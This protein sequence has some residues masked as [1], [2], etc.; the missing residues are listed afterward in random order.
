MPNS[1]EKES[2]VSFHADVTGADGTTRELKISPVK[3]LGH[4]RAAVAVLCNVS[5]PE[6]NQSRQVAEK[7]FTSSRLTRFIYAFFFQAPFPYQRN[8]DAIRASLFRRLVIHDLMEFA[9]L[10]N[11]AIALP[12]YTRW[13]DKKN[14]FVLGSEYVKGRPIVPAR[15]DEFGVRR[16]LLNWIARPMV[17]VFGIKRRKI[18]KEKS[19][20]SELLKIMRNMERLLRRAGLVGSGWQVATRTLVATANFLK[21]S[22]TDSYVL[23]DTESGI[24]AL[25]VPSYLAAGL[26]YGFPLFDSI[27]GDKKLRRFFENNRRDIEAKLGPGR[28]G[29]F[30]GH[31]DKLIFHTA[32]WKASE[33]AIFRHHLKLFLSRSLK[34]KVRSKTL[35]YWNKDGIFSDRHWEKVN[36]SRRIFSSSYF[37]LSILPTSMGK[38]V[39]LF[40]CNDD[41]RAKVRRFFKDKAYRSHLL[42]ERVDKKLALWQREGRVSGK[43]AKEIAGSKWRTNRFFLHYLAAVITPFGFRRIHRVLSDWDYAKDAFWKSCLALMSERYQL[44]LARSFISKAIAQDIMD[45]RLEP[46]IAR[47]L[48]MVVDRGEVEE[49]IRC[50]GWHLGLKTLEYFTSSLKV[51]GVTL[52]AATGNILYLLLFINTSLIRTAYTLKRMFK[53]RGRGISY[54]SALA[55]GMIP[56]LGT[57]AFPVQMYS[58]RKDFSIYLMRHLCSALGQRAPIYGG[59]STVT[60][61]A[62]VKC[63]D[64][65][66]EPLEIFRTWAEGLKRLFRPKPSETEGVTR[67]VGIRKRT[68]EPHESSSRLKTIWLNREQQCI[69]LLDLETPQGDSS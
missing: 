2:P 69:D 67:P 41:Y 51:M 13:D 1:F 18:E 27:A 45:G 42:R 10:G 11:T 17:R 68:F 24:P 33:P 62:A 57:F 25:L 47:G 64:F 21:G 44:S 14:S 48:S 58:I 52:W 65:I 37:F 5:G 22:S 20:L 23:V 61:F 43:I 59:K 63:V 39:W 9:G 32:Q 7:V 50:F 3:T 53:N 38:G 35:F 46:R 8:E 66:V 54:G 16:L 31:I 34:Q 60:E 15:P 4:G 28:T 12:L 55:F 49:Y 30:K 29:R 6:E 40:R 56:G 19:E 36:K 26:R